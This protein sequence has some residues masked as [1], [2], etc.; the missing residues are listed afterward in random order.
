ML[1]NRTRALIVVPLLAISWLVYAGLDSTPEP[2][3]AFQT[4]VFLRHAEKP[5]GGLGQLNCQGLNRSLALP[6]L[7]PER[8]GAPDYVFAANPDRRVEEGPDDEEFNYLRPLLTIAPT[9]IAHGLPINTEFN[10]NDVGD[11]VEELT[12]PQY[13]NSTIYTAWSRGYVSEIMNELLD[14]VDADESLNVARWH[15][16]DFDSVYVIKLHWRNGVAKASLEAQAQG[17]NDTGSA[18]PG[19]T[20]QATPQLAVRDNSR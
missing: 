10:A 13:R 9:A 12:E 4:L 17:L 5:T 11:I 8:F 7:L 15:R 2:E 14:E 19:E 16:E 18:C 3:E 20:Q 1:K 6:A